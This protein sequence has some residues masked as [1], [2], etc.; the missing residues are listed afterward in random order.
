M[1]GKNEWK[2][3]YSL[4][5]I[6]LKPT[7]LWPPQ[8]S[9]FCDRSV[10]L[11]HGEKYHQPAMASHWDESSGG[12]SIAHC[13]NNADVAEN[14]VQHTEKTQRK[15]RWCEEPTT[16]RE[17]ARKHYCSWYFSWRCILHSILHIEFH[18]QNWQCDKIGVCEFSTKLE[19][20]G[21]LWLFSKIP[22]LRVQKF[23]LFV[24]L[25]L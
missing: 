8:M 15:S 13:P 21:V 16:S 10:W 2:W 24:Q 17:K 20:N 12:C 3:P 9:T 5:T 7:Q 14:G 11:R 25:G 4:W 19:R 23:P 18:H 22:N 1:S 6:K